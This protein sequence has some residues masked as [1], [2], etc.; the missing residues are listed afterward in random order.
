MP[1]PHHF[2]RKITAVALTAVFL[3]ACA[4]TTGLMEAHQEATAE[5]TLITWLTELAAYQAT[6]TVTYVSN[7]NVNH[8]QISHIA[9]RGG[10]YLIE[11]IAPERLAGNVT[12]SDGEHIF[13]LHRGLGYKIALGTVDNHETKERTSLLLTNFAEAFLAGEGV[14]TSIDTGEHQLSVPVSSQH[15]YI[16]RLQL[17]MDATLNPISLI[18]YDVHGEQRIVVSYSDFVPNPDIDMSVF[19]IQQMEEIVSFG[20][21][22]D[23]STD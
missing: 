9:T 14:V 7:K 3:S 6:A 2:L 13:Q 8:Y 4:G 1:K 18:S 15:R 23:T 20:D 21:K 22:Q 17:V 10:S 12:L 19:N 11:V 5:E 16:A